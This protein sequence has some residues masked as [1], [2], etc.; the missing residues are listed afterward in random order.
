MFSVDAPRGADGEPVVSATQWAGFA[1]D[2][3]AVISALTQ[4]VV[5]LTAEV[6]ALAAR[7]GQNST[8][9][10]RPPSSDPPWSSKRRPPAG[11]SGRRPGGQVGH[12]GH[13]R[14]LAPPERVDVVVD[15]WPAGCV[16]CA[17]PLAPLAPL[18][19]AMFAGERDDGDY[20]AHQVTELPS[21]RAVVTEHRLHR[22]AC[23]GCGATTR[24]TLPEEVPPGA[25]GPRMQA[26]V[27]TLKGRFRLSCREIVE[28]GDTVLEAPLSVG[29]VTTLCQATSNALAAPVAEAVATL[30]AAAVVNADETSWKE[31]TARPWLWVAVTALVTVFQIATSRSSQVIKDLLGEDYGGTLGTDR[32][33][34][35]AWLDVAFRQV[36]WAH[37]TRDFQALVDRGGT[38]RPLGKAA[39]ALIHDLFTVWHQFRSGT[40]DRPGLQIT[41]GKVDAAL[42][43]LVHP[44][45]DN[46]DP[47]A[48]GLCRALLRLWPALWTFAEVAGV[49][50][51]N[52]AAERALRPAVLWRKGSFGTRSADGAR[53]VERLL[54]VSATCKQHGRSVFAY[55]T[56]VCAAAQRGEPVP[57]LLPAIV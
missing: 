43:A 1:P 18:V 30:P 47:Q 53:F 17:L 49:E 40:L 37:L 57:S 8:N 54:T 10:S 24:A 42:A 50:P 7:L 3:Q 36:C 35:Y 33:A 6:R 38:A 26:T 27:A 52:N 5:A 13:F 22:V 19:A 44:G 46:P 11:P 55:L 23:P 4:Q 45:Q 15:H 2:A 34:G 29:S 20:V 9:S 41:I 16:G 28:L 25:F 51:T 14:A 12:T 56:A 21:V 48:A 39:L 31:G 32:Y